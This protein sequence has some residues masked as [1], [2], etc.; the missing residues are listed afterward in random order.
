MARFLVRRIIF[1]ILTL[2]LVSVGVF[3]ISELAP[4]DL[5]KNVL[6]HQITDDQ[7]ASFNAQHGLD[8]P[9]T[10]RYVR[11]MIGSDW[12]ASE[13]IGRPIIRITDP[14]NERYS[15]WVVGVDGEYYQNYSPDGEVMIKVILQPDGT[16]IDEPMGDDIWVLDEGGIPVYWSID[17]LGRAAMWVR[18]D[19]L[20][21]WVIQM[22][23]WDTIA[24]APRRYIPLQ[25]GLL[26][27]DPGIS[28]KTRRP[29]GETLI[30]RLKNTAILAGL[31]FLFIMPIGL[32]LGLF[33]GL[34]EGKATDR[35]F[36]VSSLV[37]TATPEFANGVFLILIFSIWLKVLPGAVVFSSDRAILENPKAL[38]LPLATLTLVELGYI[39]RIT[40]ASMVEVMRQDYIR[41]AI[42]K[43]L[44]KRQIIFKHALRNALMAPITVIMLHVNWL[45]GG[46]VVVESIFGFPGV[47][48]YV[49]DAAL[50]ND[51][52][53]VEAAAMTLV[54][55]AVVSQLLADI[56]YTFLNPR[57]R[58]T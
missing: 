28:F 20:E 54:V 7:A 36:S 22:S 37:A 44:P 16:T 12:Q 53:A 39:L 52:F 48:R 45:V 42:L 15:W 32:V 24:G 34:N 35:I 23:T 11:W 29:V 56:I 27:G 13:L 18:G 40:R 4:G 2:A 33:A 17:T 9:A 8:Q 6:G 49:Y 57:I 5:A 58:Y 19:K 14:E 41:T 43:G 1:L 47:G 25:K 38:I 50:F 46:I 3:F 21:A 30:R 55:I 10:T 31:A 51:V 26:R